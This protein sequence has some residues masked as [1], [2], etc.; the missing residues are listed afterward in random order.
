MYDNI[1]NQI[2]GGVRRLLADWILLLGTHNSCSDTSGEQRRECLYFKCSSLE[3]HYWEPLQVRD[4]V[5]R[6]E[7]TTLNFLEVVQD[8]TVLP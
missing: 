6:W 8:S 5:G 7:H 1:D 3:P 2:M 4:K